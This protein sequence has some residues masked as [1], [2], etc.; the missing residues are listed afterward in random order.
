MTRW[1]GDPHPIPQ[2]MKIW[3]SKFC[4]KGDTIFA[5]SHAIS[6]YNM[7]KEPC[8]LMVENA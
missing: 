3:R 4:E 2:P 8:D 5:I 1:L 7:G 6:C